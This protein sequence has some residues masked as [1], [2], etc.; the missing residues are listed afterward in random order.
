MQIVTRYVL[1]V[2]SYLVGPKIAPPGALWPCFR[3]WSAKKH[4][5]QVRF[6]GVFVPGACRAYNSNFI[7]GSICE[8]WENSRYMQIV[9][10]YVLGVFSCLVGPKIA[11]PGALWPCF[12]AWAGLKRTHQGQFSGVFAPGVCRRPN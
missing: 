8:V 9:T 11:S 2:F 5:Y 6:W 4:A 10:R 3:A 12:R 1:G 7:S